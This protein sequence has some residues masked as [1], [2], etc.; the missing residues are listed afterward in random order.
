MRFHCNYLSII[1]S[2]EFN[3]DGQTWSVGSND[4]FAYF[5]FGVESSNDGT[6]NT[7]FKYI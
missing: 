7:V 4:T 1:E 5:A 2:L 6:N 3:I